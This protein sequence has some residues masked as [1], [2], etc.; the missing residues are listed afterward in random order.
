MAQI[1]ARRG[2]ILGCCAV[3]GLETAPLMA[4]RVDPRC[5]M[6]CRGFSGW[7]DLARFDPAGLPAC[8]DGEFSG[9][10]SDGPG[11]AGHSVSMHPDTAGV[12]LAGNREGF[13]EAPA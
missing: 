11:D 3:V 7:L 13:V 1:R 9:G 8:H 5:G 6:L 2:R 10:S 4:P 12:A